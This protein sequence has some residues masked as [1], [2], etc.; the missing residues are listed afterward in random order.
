MPELPE[1]ETI[2]RDLRGL[3]V[4]S[5][6]GG[7]RS[8]WPRTL[9]SHEPD[10]FGAGVSGREIVGVGRRGKQL[11][12]M[13]GPVHSAAPGPLPAGSSAIASATAEASA[14]TGRRIDG[15]QYCRTFLA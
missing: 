3:V 5:R 12:I 6:I 4:G 14:D 2:A 9:R 1:V 11:L 7:A 10:A 15:K 8:N 13:L